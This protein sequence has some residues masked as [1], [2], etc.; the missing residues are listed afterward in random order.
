[1]QQARAEEVKDKDLF[2]QTTKETMACFKSIKKFLKKKRRS[3]TRENRPLHP[4]NQSSPTTWTHTL[5]RT[6]LQASETWSTLLAWGTALPFRNLPTTLPLL[7]ITTKW[8]MVV[9]WTSSWTEWAAVDMGQKL[10]K[11]I[12]V[13]LTTPTSPF[14]MSTKMIRTSLKICKTS[15]EQSITLKLLRLPSMLLKVPMPADPSQPKVSESWTTL[16]AVTLVG[17]RRRSSC[18]QTTAPHCQSSLMTWRRSGWTTCTAV[19][20][21]APTP[22][23]VPSRPL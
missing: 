16:P 22:G 15:T 7:I 1:M 11:K 4:K 12:V 3:S 5:P 8:G 18:R 20:T 2:N 10:P 6:F 21:W 14:L 23:T 17:L 9:P 19:W 13:W